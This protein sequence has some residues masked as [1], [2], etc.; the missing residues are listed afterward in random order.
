M[1]AGQK[2][3]PLDC[4]ELYHKSDE[5]GCT[6]GRLYTSKVAAQAVAVGR[7]EVAQTRHIQS[8]TSPNVPI[9]EFLIGCT[10]VL[11]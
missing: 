7:L 9:L 10:P 4:T 5:G 2:P 3:Q 8:H 6:A 11:R 1:A